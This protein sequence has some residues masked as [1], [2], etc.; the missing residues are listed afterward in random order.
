M[1]RVN[2]SRSSRFASAASC[3]C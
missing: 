2:C 1:E 3:A